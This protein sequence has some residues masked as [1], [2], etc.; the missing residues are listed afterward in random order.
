SV[1]V[2]VGGGAVAN[3]PALLAGG[4]MSN[5]L[6]SVAD[7]FDYV[8]IDAPP[9]LEVSDAMPLLSA[10]D[11][12]VMVARIGH[13]RDLAAKRLAQLLGR[14][15]SA[16]LI[17]AVVNCVPRKDIERYGFSWAPA[18]SGARRKLIGR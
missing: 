7:E 6:R 8:L 16:P 13:T 9:P 18:D 4:S 11:G 5:L 1:S 3:P 17:G 12:I 14:T 2:L 15:A 10:V